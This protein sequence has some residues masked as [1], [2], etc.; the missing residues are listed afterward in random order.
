VEYG[1]T[2]GLLTSVKDLAGV[3]SS[4]GYDASSRLTSETDPKQTIRMRLAYDAT[5]GRVS[6]QWDALNHHTTFAWDPV[7]QVSTMTDPNGGR[8][9]DDYNNGVLFARV[10]PKGRCSFYD[11]NNDVVLTSVVNPRGDGATFDYNDAGDLISTRN[12]TGLV[13]TSY[14]TRHDPVHAVDGKGVSADYSY[15]SAGN[16]LSVTTTSYKTDSLGNKNVVDEVRTNSFTYYSNGQVHTATDARGKT[17]TYTYDAA[18]GDL[19]D[20]TSPAGRHSHYGYDA[21]GRQ[22]TVV[23]PRG[24]DAGH[25]LANYTTTIAYTARDQARVVTDPGGHVT[26]SVYDN[27]LGQLTSVTDANTHVTSY[28][29]YPDGQIHTVVEPGATAPT[30]TYTY[31]NNGNVATVTDPDGRVVTYHYDLAN[32]VTS[33]VTPLGT[34]TYGYDNNGRVTSSKGP[35]DTV[36]TS[37]TLNARGEAIY[38]ANPDNSSISYTYDVHGNRKSMTNKTA[39]GQTVSTTNYTWDDYDQLTAATTTYGTAT[40]AYTYGYDK[41]GNLT[42]STGA[43]GARTYGYDDDGLLTSV[44][45]STET[46]ATYTYTS[47]AQPDTITYGDGS[48]QQFGYDTAGRLTSRT[49]LTSAGAR[50]LDDS[51]GLDGVGNPTTITHHKATGDVSDTFVYNAQDFLT[52]AC[53]SAT[54]CAGSTDHLAWTYDA[55]GNRTSETRAAGTT[56]YAYDAATGKVSST[57]G[58]T[59][60]TSFTYNPQGEMT[61]DGTSTFT[62]NPDATT[63]TQTTA[64]VSTTFAYDGDGRRLEA[65]VGSSGAASSIT[66]FDW[67]PQTYLLTAETDGANAFRR[68]YSFGL[69][70][71]GFTSSATGTGVGTTHFLHSDLQGSI[72]AVTGPAG[73][74]ES[75]SSYEPYGRV[76]SYVP[77]DTNAPTSPLGWAGQ[78]TDPD[79]QSNL[80]AR[81]YNPTLGSFTVPDPA[82]ATSASATYTYGN[83]NPMVYSDPSGLDALSTLGSFLS[84]M[85]PLKT[86]PSAI[87]AAKHAWDVC[88]G[89][90]G[91]CAMAVVD[92]VFKT[93]DAVTSVTGTGAILG[94]LA[95]LA[96]RKL[97]ARFMEDTVEVFAAEGVAPVIRN[98]HLAGDVHPVTGVPFDEGGFPDFGGWRH[99]DVPDVTIT[100]TGTRSGDFAA[101]NEA[102]G[103]SRTPEDYTW[104]HHQDYG[105]MQLIERGIH[106][107]TGHTGG[108]S[109]WGKP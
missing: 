18:H 37:L 69:G 61:G 53:Y 26:T 3:T 48:H 51:Y 57:S 80:R 55:V 60:T 97:A 36:A 19:T 39:S 2:N 59:G 24:Y 84:S 88:H 68:G 86:I 108:F 7:E 67:D 42:A 10:D 92:A 29:Y 102:A 21:V 28:T 1:Y 38:V 64:G 85:N 87:S 14:N 101:A 95:S 70:P 4:Y 16:V 103:L 30:T 77:L 58:P 45:R 22:T 49:D 46:L 72:T 44:K 31:D 5:T 75:T 50:L 104:H 91:S 32:E 82:S 79:G 109:I 71:I 73:A 66:R 40:F 9:I 99:P 35:G 78:Y 62:Y 33:K 11:F 47:S 20:I 25:T 15:D 81:R 93:V 12:Q 56:T 27:D 41:N 76:R 6:D 65:K 43:D 89:A 74:I 13:T 8:W 96:A 34:Y 23:D 98:A 105:V 63:A 94:K 100:P 106:A 52:D 83:A 90:K 17:T 107:S 54:S